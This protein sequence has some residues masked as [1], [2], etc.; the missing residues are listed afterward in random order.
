MTKDNRRLSSASKRPVYVSYITTDCVDA[1]YMIG[2]LWNFS[3]SALYF[4]ASAA[5]SLAF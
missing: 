1:S 2:M 3:I 4:W 5:S